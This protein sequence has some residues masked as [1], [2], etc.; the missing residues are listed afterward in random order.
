MTKIK[1]LLFDLDGTLIAL[2]EKKAQIDFL[3]RAIFWAKFQKNPIRIFSA[4][5]VCKNTMRYDNS[6]D[7]I[8]N[9]A[10]RAFANEMALEPHV[11]EVL[12][13][14][15]VQTHFPKLKKYF[16]IICDAINFIEWSKNKFN[17]YLA[18][19]PFWTSDIVN[20]RLS[21]IALDTT[22]FKYHSHSKNMKYSKHSKLFFDEFLLNN[23][24]LANECLMIGNKPELDGLAAQSGLKV[25]ILKNKKF[26]DHFL[27]REQKNFLYQE[28]N[29]Q[30]LKSYLER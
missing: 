13:N 5:K 30:E 25:F 7:F 8:Y 28:G 9:K 3:I 16:S 27:V 11:C 15:F 26:I 18:T 12:L 19:N 2:D 4:L 24:L 29:Y 14:L 10:V 1:N 21:W 23:N 20:L 6:C 22:A 17:L